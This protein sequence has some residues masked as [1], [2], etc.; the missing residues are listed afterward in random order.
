MRLEDMITDNKII[1]RG[2]WRC[3]LSDLPWRDC[4]LIKIV[5]LYLRYTPQWNKIGRSRVR[6]LMEKKLKRK[7]SDLL[8][9]YAFPAPDGRLFPVNVFLWRSRCVDFGWRASSRWRRSLQ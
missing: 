2:L 6:A 3:I 7:S 5:Y 4:Q 9:S 8:D 1:R